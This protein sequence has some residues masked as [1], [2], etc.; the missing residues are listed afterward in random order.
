MDERLTEA[1]VCWENSRSSDAAGIFASRSS[2]RPRN[3]GV[4]LKQ[5]LTGPADC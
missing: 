3:L 5:D 4:G 2:E 1:P